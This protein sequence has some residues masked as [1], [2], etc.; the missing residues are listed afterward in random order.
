M[1]EKPYDLMGGL[2]LLS[3]CVWREARGEPAEGQRGVAWVVKNRTLKSSWWNGH[4]EQ[5][6]HAVILQ[7]FQFSS[8]NSQDTQSQRWPR[9]DDPSFVDC[10]TAAEG[11]YTGTDTEDPTAGAT[12]YYDT[13]ISWPAAWG[14]EA[15]YVNT[16]NVGRLKFYK[17][18]GAA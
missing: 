9:D 13:S 10:K 11:V 6:Y 14:Y 2:D 4:N 17:P 18:K 5:N 12:S 15:D 8:F 16:L 7:P 3:L 1:V